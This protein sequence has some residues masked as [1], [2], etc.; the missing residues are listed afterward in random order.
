MRNRNDAAK[1]VDNNDEHERSSYP[2]SASASASAAGAHT[3]SSSIRDGDDAGPVFTGPVTTQLRPQAAH[4]G[5]DTSS[6]SPPPL[7]SAAVSVSPA[8]AGVGV[9]GV[10][11]FISGAP[12]WLLAHPLMSTLF[13]DQQ[14][15]RRAGE[16]GGA[17]ATV[18][19]PTATASSSTMATVT[20][21][22][23]SSNN[24]I[25]SVVEDD[26]ISQQLQLQQHTFNTLLAPLSS[27]SPE[28]PTSSLTTPILQDNMHRGRSDDVPDIVDQHKKDC[29]V[30]G[31][32][33]TNKAPNVITLTRTHFSSPESRSYY[34][35][36]HDDDDEYDYHPDCTHRGPMAGHFAS[37]TA[38][39]DAANSSTFATTTAALT[40]DSS[41]DGEGNGTLGNKDVN[42]DLF[43][44]HTYPLTLQRS[45]SSAFGCPYSSTSSSFC[46]FKAR[47]RVR[48]LS[49]SGYSDP[50]A[51]A[52]RPVWK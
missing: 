2:A 26:I 29:G 49:N 25:T 12:S 30:I 46:S 47:A 13:G 37:L 7:P 10:P 6:S 11:S 23:T 41:G 1:D 34:H 9:G 48:T 16:G 40:G 32:D 33:G 45:A 50:G 31:T 52:F 17:V 35:P 43:L 38:G 18:V 36:L 5:Q 44:K 4:G 51:S 24:N 39:E 14:Q 27:S 19:T 22:T 15:Q 3:R 21:K 20:G 42:S 28:P 8:V